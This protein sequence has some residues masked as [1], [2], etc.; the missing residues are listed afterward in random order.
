MTCLKLLWLPPSP[1][2]I[3]Y[4]SWAADRNGFSLL[5][6][7]L[8]RLTARYGNRSLLVACHDEY[9]RSL[10]EAEAAGPGVLVVLSGL[11]TLTGV[12]G[13]VASAFPKEPIAWFQLETIF[14]PSGLLDRVTAHHESAR[15]HFTYVADLPARLGPEVADPALLRRLASIEYEGYVPSPREATQGLTTVRAEPFTAASFYSVPKLAG[16]SRLESADEADRARQLLESAPAEYDFDLIERWSA[17]SFS[18]ANFGVPIASERRA[19][20]RLLYLSPGSFYSGAEEC[21]RGLAEGLSE[22]NFHQT[23]VVGIEGLFSQRLRRTGCEVIATNWDFRRP[24][25]TNERFASEV[26]QNTAPEIIHCNADPGS[27]FLD[28]AQASGQPLIAHLRTTLVPERFRLFEAADAVIAVSEYAKCRLI[29]SGTASDRIVVIPDGVDA[30]RFSPGVFDKLRSRAHFGLPHDGFVI[31]MIARAARLKRHDLLLDAFA[32][33]LDVTDRAHVVLVGDYGEPDVISMIRQTVAERGLGGR[34]SW[35]PFQSDIRQI[36]CAADVLVLPSDEEALGTCV[37]EAMSLEIPVVVSDSGGTIELIEK[38]VS[39]LAMSGGDAASLLNA[40]LQLYE[41]ESL[42]HEI[43]RNARRHV[44]CRFT[45][46]H[47]AGQVAQLFR[48][49]L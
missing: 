40:L 37:L 28:I 21:L 13:E 33:L 5:G 24:G 36:E 1:P 32:H 2:S 23:A 27:P 26:L 46:R 45:L 17:T 18:P 38:G 4:R 44:H 35:L 15:N 10:A 14:A 3:S 16:M 43:G 25:Q 48:R 9:D 19:G 8:A 7:F 29:R 42:R 6:W 11:R 39:G 20:P 30:E 22:L 49:M 47:H 41:S 34:F 31:L 12:L